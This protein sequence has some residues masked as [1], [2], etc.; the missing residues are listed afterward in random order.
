MASLAVV[1]TIAALSAMLLQIEANRSRQQLFGSDQKRAIN[2]AEAGLSEAWFGLRTGLTGSVGDASAPA[3]FGDGLFWVTATE[4]G[5]DMIS[6]EST[7]MCGAGRAT[8]GLV[9]K[10]TPVSIASLGIMGAD[11]ITVGNRVKVDSYDSNV[12]AA[13]DGTTPVS[14][15]FRLQSNGDVTIGSSAKIYSDVTPGPEGSVIVGAGAVVTGATAP[16]A[17][18]EILP[19]ID[20]PS[21]SPRSYTAPATGAVTIPSGEASYASIVVPP[22][23]TATI[24]GPATLTLGKLKVADLGVLK[25]DTAN[26][27]ITLYVADWLSIAPT[28]TVSFSERDPKRVSMLVNAS[29]YADYDGDSAE[30]APVEFDY[31]G[32]FY[33]SLYAPK[34]A[35]RIPTAFQL[36]GTVAAKE[37]TV[38]ANSQIHFDVALESE[39][40]G[41]ASSVQKLA[42]NVIEV[43]EEISRVLAVDPFKALG[44]N[45]ATLDKPADAHEDVAYQIHISYIDLSDT[46][47]TYRGPEAD[48]DWG[49]VKTVVKLLRAPL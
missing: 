27:P 1:M 4:L 8:L 10:R 36:F 32:V 23:V 25:F 22:L 19:Q 20:V 21:F 13:P 45:E 2:I 6:L 28:A 34:A 49:Q 24:V 15:S 42:W 33:G 31:S 47:R 14:T 35:L 37:L 30:D 26:G 44:V 9:V 7:G 3:R 43:P 40:N 39:S 46:A 17:T 41:D 18:S 38:G 5:D 11:G 29:E 12:S 48:F 16:S